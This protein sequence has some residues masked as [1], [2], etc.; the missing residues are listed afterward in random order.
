MDVLSQVPELAG[1]R[2]GQISA[3]IRAGQIP[4]RRGAAARRGVGLRGSAALLRARPGTDE[5]SPAALYGLALCL[6]GTGHNDEAAAL[7]AP[8]A[9]ANQA[10]YYPAH[11]WLAQ[12]LLEAAEPTAADRHLA[13]VH[14]QLALKLQ[15][16]EASVHALLAQHYWNSARYEEAEPHLVSAVPAA[17]ALHLRLAELHAARQDWPQAA[18]EANLAVPFFRDRCRDAPQEVAARVYWAEAEM[19]SGHH[20]DAVSI[21]RAELDSAAAAQPVYLQILGRVYAS[22]AAAVERNGKAD[23]AQRLQLV[24]EGLKYR[25]PAT[26][27]CCRP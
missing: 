5:A 25:R 21:L 9:P 22:W 10:G 3:R 26:A 6:D 7:M 20:A 16:G 8:L 18:K 2:A 1:S 19:L 14:L 15:P 12:R 11:L 17:P 4:A 27:N 13:E 23:P 24:E